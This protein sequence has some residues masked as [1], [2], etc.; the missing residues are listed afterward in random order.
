MK[1]FLPRMATAFLA[2]CLA[3]VAFA[4]DAPAPL[5]TVKSVTGNV[6]VTTADGYQPLTVDTVLKAGDRMT[7]LDGSAVTLTYQGGCVDVVNTASI[8]T[9]PVTSPCS[10]VAGSTGEGASAPT[11]RTGGSTGDFTPSDGLIGV[12]ILAGATAVVWAL[13]EMNDDEAPVSP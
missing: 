13:G 7:V 8:Y 9:V 4:Q 10:A 3:S 6:L 5:A 11:G 12:G 2:S 1:K